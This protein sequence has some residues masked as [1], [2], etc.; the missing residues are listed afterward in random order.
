[1]LR[2]LAID[3]GTHCGL[4]HNCTPTGAVTAWTEHLATAR[5]ITEWGRSRMTRRNDPRILRLSKILQRIPKPD[6]CVFEDVCFQTY[7]KQ[8]QLWSSLR[9]AVWLTLG[10]SCILEC[11]PVATLKKFATGHGGATKPMMETALRRANP[12]MFKQLQ[13]L[14]DDAVDALWLFKWAEKYLARIPR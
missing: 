9:A 7:T 12:D 8:T 6:V 2:I 5:E 4:A 11:V 14:G 10:E 1:M 3:L 13:T